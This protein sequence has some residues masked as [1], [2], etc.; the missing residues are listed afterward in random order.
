MVVYSHD[1]HT[2]IAPVGMSYLVSQYC[3]SQGSQ[4]DKT[5]FTFLLKEHVKHFMMLAIEIKFW[6]NTSLISCSVIKI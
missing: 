2:T 3:T 5:M 4:L 6:V 1:V